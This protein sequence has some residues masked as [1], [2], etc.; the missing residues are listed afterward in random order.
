MFS[1]MPICHPICS[2]I[3]RPRV[4]IIDWRIK[5]LGSNYCSKRAPRCRNLRTK[6]AYIFFFFFLRQFLRVV[7]MRCR[8]HTL[9]RTRVFI[10]TV[11]FVRTLKIRSLKRDDGSPPRE[12]IFFPLK[13]ANSGKFFYIF[14]LS[15]SSLK[16]T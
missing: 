11:I 12:I 14:S 10:C 2:E 3:Q 13:D 8:D 4:D 1:L 9:L 16:R 7:S 6:F 15:L 5:Y